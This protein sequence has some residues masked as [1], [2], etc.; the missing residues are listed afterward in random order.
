M[1]IRPHRDPLVL[2]RVL[3]A[4]ALFGVLVPASAR[5]VCTGDCNSDDDVSISELIQA[6]NIS[7]GQSAVTTCPAIDAD[8]DGEVE[9]N[10]LV[11]AVSGSLNGCP[12]APTATPPNTHTAAP[13]STATSI[14]SATPTP[15]ATANQPPVLPTASIYRTFPGFPIAVPL[16]VIDP[17]GG[18][19]ACAVENLPAGAAFDGETGVLS[20]TPDDDQLGA[21][22]VPFECS[23]DGSP[24]LSVAGKLTFRVTARDTCVIPSCDPASGCT[25]TLPPPSERCCDGVPLAR[26]AEPVAGCPEGRVLYT[27]QNESVDTFGRVQNCDVMKL[28]TFSQASAQVRFRTETRCMNTLNRLN[29][30]A[31]MESTSAT[32]QELFNYSALPQKYAE[33]DDGFARYRTY[34]FII[35]GGGPYFDLEGA[36]ANLTL[37]LRDSDN[38]VVTHQVRVRLSFTPQPELPDVDPSP[39]PTAT[40]TA[41]PG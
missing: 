12:G 28:T 15:T 22:Y 24:P 6:V 29:L 20:W 16:G 5:A 21:F 11:A 32:R 1:S 17:E 9:I 26:V 3:A 27:G 19:V 13:T 38:V 35:G 8:G 39:P 4:L 30:L 40:R 33:E 34:A 10:E 37:T 23:D 36:E 41:S 31:H 7:L 18:P 2:A 25:V 14:T